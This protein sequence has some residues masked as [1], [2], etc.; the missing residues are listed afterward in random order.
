[1]PIRATLILLVAALAAWSQ[2]L[3]PSINFVVSRTLSLKPT[4]YSH[5]NV[6]RQG[7]GSYTG[8]EVDD[9]PPYPIY[10]TTPHFER[11]FA[12]CLPHSL[13]ATPS[14]AASANVVGISS[15]LVSSE[16]TPSGG[17]LVASLNGNPYEAVLPIQFDLYDSQLSLISETS[18][19]DP[20]SYG[21]RSLALA[22][23][24]NDGRPDLIAVSL[25]QAGEG[26]YSLLNVGRLWFFAGN[27]DGTFQTGVSS[28]L[29]G[30]FLMPGYT[31]FVVADLNGDGKPDLALTGGQ[32]VTTIVIG[33]GDG[34][35]AFLPANAVATLP[36]AKLPF[37]PTG[38]GSI[39]AADLNGDGKLDLVFGPYSMGD[40]PTGVAVAMGNGDGTFQTPTFFPARLTSYALGASQ[41][42]LGDVNQ[43]GI[44]DIVTSGGA[45]P[46]YGVTIL[47]GDGKGGFPS[48]RDMISTAITH[49]A[50]ALSI[51]SISMAME[52]WT[53]SSE[54]E[55]RSS[56]RTT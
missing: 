23:I 4:P 42:A 5:I 14:A 49:T 56:F 17:Y 44:P 6:V 22:D 41:I 32:G 9:R 54:T 24:N 53:S 16:W 43:D 50:S 45:S 25:A 46:G 51:C 12:N 30:D 36:S 1:M 3:C 7:D 34:T 10:S 40:T 8:F 35:F 21:F 27:G 15:Q 20:G 11:Q 55:A 29:P 52:L 48:R 28:S 2:S 19:S 47:F 37:D 39:A 31:S 18:V 13:P 26:V 33:K 38:P